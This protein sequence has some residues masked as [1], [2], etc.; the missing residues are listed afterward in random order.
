MLKNK[1]LICLSLFFL[2]SCGLD[3]SRIA[4]GYIEAFK[5]IKNTVITQENEFI[6]PDIIENIPYASMTLKIGRGVPGLVILESFDDGIE[7]WVSADGVYLLIEEGRIIKTA[8]LFKKIA[9]PGRRR[10]LASTVWGTT[11]NLGITRGP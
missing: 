2:Y 10:K 1:N 7:T 9:C 4:P 5:T 6:T 3:T 11:E 8:G